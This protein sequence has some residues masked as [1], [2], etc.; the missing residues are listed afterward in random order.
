MGKSPPPSP[1]DDSEHKKEFGKGD[2]GKGDLI[3]EALLSSTEWVPDEPFA[4]VQ[5]EKVFD[6]V[7]DPP[8]PKHDWD[9]EFFTQL[10]VPPSAGAALQ[11][12]LPALPKK[13]KQKKRIRK[14][15]PKIV[16][17][18]YVYVEP[19]EDDVLLGRGGRSNHHPGNKRYREEVKN[20]RKWYQEIREKEEKTDLSQCLVDYVHSYGGRFLEEDKTTKVGSW[21]IVPDLLARRKASQALRE[22]PDPAKRAAKRTRHL[23]KKA[24]EGTR[25]RRKE[26]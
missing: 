4:D 15:R 11:A 9:A 16:P 21:Y 18:T 12:S 26:A 17:E 5:Y 1:E 13:R 25:K 14:P 22:D 3:K 8:A 7:A 6:G 10:G 20:L 24:R 2:L 23:K 19:H